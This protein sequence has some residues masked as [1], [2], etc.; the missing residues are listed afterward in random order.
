MRMCLLVLCLSA[1]RIEWGARAPTAGDAAQ[2][3]EVMIYTSAYPPVV[4]ALG[5][6]MQKVLPGIDVKWFQA[7][8]EKLAARLDAELLADNPGADLLMA[9]DPM[10]YQR[11]K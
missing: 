1:C 2:R 10:Y 9:S 3:A 8:S 11:L 7:G 6:H 5:A 4:A